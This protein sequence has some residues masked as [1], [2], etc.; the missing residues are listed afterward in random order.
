MAKKILCTI[1][2]ISLIACN[3][4]DSP[5]LEKDFKLWNDQTVELMTSIC[6]L[7]EYDKLLNH[8]GFNW[9]SENEGRSKLLKHL[10]KSNSDLF[11]KSELSIYEMFSFDEDGYSCFVWNDDDILFYYQYMKFNN[12]DHFYYEAYKKGTENFNY[13]RSLISN[14]FLKT[15]SE[16]FYADVMQSNW[17]CYTSLSIEDGEISKFNCKWFNLTIP[18]RYEN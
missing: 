10:Y 13:N 14:D 17:Q 2:L 18:E 16:C 7:C 5:Y 11:L 1:L 12:S 6:P 15:R 4:G 9:I 8:S 3:R